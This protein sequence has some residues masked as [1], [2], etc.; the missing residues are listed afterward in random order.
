MKYI[1]LCVSGVLIVSFV[2]L[3]TSCNHRDDSSCEKLR[4]RVVVDS[5]LSKIID[6][7][8]YEITYGDANSIQRI[9]ELTDDG[10]VVPAGLLFE[11]CAFH[12][13]CRFF[14]P[15]HNP[16]LIRRNESTLV[17]WSV[18]ETGKDE[19]GEG[20]DYAKSTIIEIAPRANQ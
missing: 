14:D 3:Y 12:Q 5:D 20:D 18:G 4:Y 2:Y 19:N 11:K 16:Y 7:L 13:V 8:Q 10:S 1:H 15:N 6:A 9:R 17:L